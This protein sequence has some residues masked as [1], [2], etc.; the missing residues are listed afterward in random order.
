M[1]IAYATAADDVALDGNNSRNSPFTSSLIRRLN[2]PGLTIEAM[3]SRVRRDVFESNRRPAAAGNVQFAARRLLPQP[4]R[5]VALGKAA[6]Q[7][8]YRCAREL[9]PAVS[10]LDPSFRCAAPARHPPSQC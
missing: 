10:V 4:D 6:R 3:F 1:F 7:R 9:H 5:P 2:E 8:R